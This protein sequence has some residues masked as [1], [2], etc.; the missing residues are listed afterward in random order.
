MILC[1][2]PDAEKR[3]RR[4]S[5][6]LQ[7]RRRL[8]ESDSACGSDSK[9]PNAKPKAQTEDQISLSILL[10]ISHSQT[11]STKSPVQASYFARHKKGMKDRMGGG[12]DEPTDHPPV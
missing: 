2:E 4:P 7:K 9:S 3:R 11:T 10:C 1:K 12:S 6:K 8:Q 5:W